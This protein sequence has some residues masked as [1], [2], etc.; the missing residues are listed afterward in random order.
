MIDCFFF[1]RP[2]TG[3]SILKSFENSSCETGEKI[4]SRLHT[5]QIPGDE[6]E[7]G[8]LKRFGV[9]WDKNG[10]RCL[11][12]Y[13]PHTGGDHLHINNTRKPVSIQEKEREDD[14]GQSGCIPVDGPRGGLIWEKPVD[15]NIQNTHLGI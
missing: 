15:G 4:F 2:Q 11:P 14:D 13:E 8:I 1:E 12:Q 9:C 6:G 7:D 5:R 3:D 10:L